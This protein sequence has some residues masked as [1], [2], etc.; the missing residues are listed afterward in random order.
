MILD[1]E[2]GR[3]I[4]LPDEVSDEFARALKMMMI[5]RLEERARDA[6]RQV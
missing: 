6:E 3:E 2:D 4:K 1:M 5:L